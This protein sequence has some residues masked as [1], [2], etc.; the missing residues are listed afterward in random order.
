M[1][2]ARRF[3]VL[4]TRGYA[5]DTLAAACSCFDGHDG[6]GAVLLL[7]LGC[8]QDF[9]C[10]GVFGGHPQSMGG[11]IKVRAGRQSGAIKWGATADRWVREVG[12]NGATPRPPLGPDQTCLRRPR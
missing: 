6:L 7:T 11:W 3:E 8:T 4:V 1:H 5:L 9:E 12:W 2:S 10:T